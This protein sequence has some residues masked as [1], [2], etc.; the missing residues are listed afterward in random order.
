MLGRF[1][2]TILLC[3]AVLGLTL[4]IGATA[5]AAATDDSAARTHTCV[6]SWEWNHFYVGD[7]KADV[8]YLFDTR[9]WTVWSA[10]NYWVKKYYACGSYSIVKVKYWWNGY[11]YE[12]ANAWRW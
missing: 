11:Y 10:G 12:V 2:R 6:D 1:W 3:L 8:E 5:P 9:G 4:S 7:R